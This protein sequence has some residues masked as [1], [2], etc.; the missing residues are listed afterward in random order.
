M[1]KKE[2]IQGFWTYSLFS[3][4]NKIIS[5]VKDFIRSHIIPEGYQ[6]DSF[7][8]GDKFVSI[9]RKPF[10]PHDG[11]FSS[12]LSAY[13]REG[14]LFVGFIFKRMTQLVIY[15]TLF[16][17]GLAFLWGF[18][19]EFTDLY[20]YIILI[21]PSIILM[22]FMAFFT[23]TLNSHKEF[24]ASSSAPI[25]GNVIA[26]IS[27]V[28]IIKCG[29]AG[30][31]T[32]ISYNLIYAGVQAIYLWTFARKYISFGN[33]YKLPDSAIE[34]YNEFILNSLKT[35]FSQLLIPISELVVMYYMKEYLPPGFITLVTYASRTI[36][37][38]ISLIS[39]P[40]T[41]ILYSSLSKQAEEQKPS[42][43][44][45]SLNVIHIAILPLCILIS[46]SEITV[47]TKLFKINPDN[48]VN[49]SRIFSAISLSLYFILMNRCIQ[50][51]LSTCKKIN[52]LSFS[53]ILFALINLGSTLFFHYCVADQ[54]NMVYGYGI[55]IIV[56]SILMFYMIMRNK[57]LEVEWKDILVFITGTGSSILFFILSTQIFTWN[58]NYIKYP[59]I[60]I[61]YLVHLMI[62]RRYIKII[63]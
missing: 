45:K 60:L 28:I 47:I 20:M 55:S 22:F 30:I 27:L 15:I 49:F 56:Q 19:H 42:F 13:N 18:T 61:V 1:A 50:T 6:S 3:I 10:C 63:L 16:C 5:L 33:Y 58:N 51:T 57:L 44:T 53:N 17:G 38:I 7:F 23:S 48:I 62:F 54:F 2:K 12:L 40:I 8:Q 52:Q 32:L 46:C 9:F 36:H 14:S 25:I 43:I 39:S 24:A 34:Q 37:S 41:N 21:S 59:S 26:F 35:F 29:A 11:H 4:A 31:T